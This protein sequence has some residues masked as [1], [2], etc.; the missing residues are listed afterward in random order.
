MAERGIFSVEELANADVD[1]LTKIPGL[2]KSKASRMV[3][4]AKHMAGVERRGSVTDGS[5]A[6]SES[7]KGQINLS[8]ASLYLNQELSL[9]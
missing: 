1:Q 2:G 5:E 8:D 4:A 7:E 9:I 6:Q 3:R